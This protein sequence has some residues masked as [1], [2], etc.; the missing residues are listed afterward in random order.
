MT[1]SWNDF[2]LL[3]VKHKKLDFPTNW[4]QYLLIFAATVLVNSSTWKRLEVLVKI[5]I[6]YYIQIQF[7][8]N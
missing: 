5:G 1:D 7:R 4:N 2:T 3:P 6:A 8:L